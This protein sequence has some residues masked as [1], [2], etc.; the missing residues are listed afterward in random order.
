MKSSDHQ[1]LSI[2]LTAVLLLAN[3]AGA[4]AGSTSDPTFH[5][6]VSEVRLTFF[7]NDGGNQDLAVRSDDFAVVDNERIVRQ[8]H[9]FSRSAETNVN[10]VVLLDSSESVLSRFHRE[11]AGTLQLISQTRW[12][13]DDHLAIV[14]FGQQGSVV[15]CS[16][17]CRDSGRISNILSAKA[18][19]LTP[20]FDTLRLAADLVGQR[21]TPTTRSVII[22]F[23][24]GEDTISYHSAGEALESL[25]RGETTIYP[26][27]LNSSHAS[28]GIAT[29]KSLA[30]ATGGRYLS[31]NDGAPAV[32][33]G[34]LNDLHN[35]Y[36]VTY[37]LPDNS[38]GFHEVRILPTHNLN[39][40]FRCRSGYYYSNST[41]AMGGL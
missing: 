37:A 13:R 33:S 18:E 23:S 9:S 6:T 24:D 25:R 40:R 29:L 39:L 22:L 3:P 8:F 36:T 19:G 7:A 35:S 12:I 11:I 27:D 16:G 30:A 20:L 31:I 2:L 28:Q 41:S 5:A 38:S 21:Q 34:L 32:I 14:T 10:V 15:Q 26:V 1:K 4:H 17:N